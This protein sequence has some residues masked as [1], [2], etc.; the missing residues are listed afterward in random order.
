[1]RPFIKLYCIFNEM[2][3]Y[4]EDQILPSNHLEN[5][6]EHMLRLRY[7]WSYL[8]SSLEVCRFFSILWGGIWEG[9]LVVISQWTWLLFIVFNLILWGLGKPCFWRIVM[10]R[11]TL[12]YL[13][14]R[15]QH[16]SQLVASSNR[17][18]H[19]WFQVWE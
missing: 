13:S 7:L 10:S 17:F 8:L 1:M 16:I 2:L 11:W 9:D 12:S 4:Y 6:L 14:F 18:V 19:T 15:Q 3:S 5:H